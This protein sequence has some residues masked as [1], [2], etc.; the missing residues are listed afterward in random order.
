[1]KRVKERRSLIEMIVRRKKNWIGH[2][3]RGC[4]MLKEIIE[5]RFERK[6]S[7]G[8]KR[9]GMLDSLLK[10][11]NFEIMKRRTI[12]RIAWRNW[13]PGTCL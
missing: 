7:R 12:D 9:I 13:T 1:M 3:L 11:E 4:G 6:R 10:G 2:V 8:R 5:G